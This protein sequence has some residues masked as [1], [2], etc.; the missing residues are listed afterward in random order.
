[1]PELGLS[2]KGRER[3]KVCKKLGEIQPEKNHSKENRESPHTESENGAWKL[4]R[5]DKRKW[6]QIQGPS[7]KGT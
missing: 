5:I 4:K 6:Y 1:M 2:R 3:G 7:K